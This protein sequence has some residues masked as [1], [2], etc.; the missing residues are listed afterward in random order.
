MHFESVSHPLESQC[1]HWLELMLWLM[2]DVQ[3]LGCTYKATTLTSAV[4]IELTRI[5]KVCSGRLSSNF[6][7]SLMMIKFWYPLQHLSI[8]L[9]SGIERLFQA[10]EIPIISGT[11][12]S[13]L[14]RFSS[15]N[16]V[17]TALSIGAFQ[18]ETLNFGILAW[19]ASTT[20][21]SGCGKGAC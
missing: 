5:S 16:S 3:E 4:T 10:S 7:T 9:L 17:F 18:C 12:L 13:R 6:W 21:G 1:C 14:F 11:D 15:V 20:R 2:V 19:S 8:S